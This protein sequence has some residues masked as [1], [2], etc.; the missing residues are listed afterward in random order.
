MSILVKSEDED[1]KCRVET[2]SPDRTQS[3]KRRR[4]AEEEAT[5]ALGEDKKKLKLLKNPKIKD[6]NAFR[7]GLDEDTLAARLKP[8]GLDVY[9]VP[10]D[11]ADASVPGSREFF[12]HHFGG[13]PQG[14]CRSSGKKFLQDHPE[15]R[16]RDFISLKLTWNPHAPPLSMLIFLGS[17]QWLYL[18]EYKMGK[19]APLT[20]REWKAQSRLM[21]STWTAQTVT[22]EEWYHRQDRI[23][24]HLRKQL[25]RKPT[26][27]DCR[28]AAADKDNQFMTVTAKDVEHEY[29]IG[30]FQVNIWTMKCVGY[31]EEIQ[32]PVL[33][34][35]DA[36][37][38]ELKAKRAETKRR[39]GESKVKKEGRSRPKKEEQ[40]EDLALLKESPRKKPGASG[41]KRKRTDEDSDTES[42]GDGDGES[43]RVV[44]GYTARPSTR[45]PR[46]NAVRKRP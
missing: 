16:R 17:G 7:L 3:R 45:N 36:F 27:E 29:D 8:I 40:V 37:D 2:V 5:E 28:A 35:F 46:P 13:A 32:Q 42:D 22:G 12:S 33:D 1:L 26:D 21:K 11:Q 20:T 14:T 25:G 6:A 18:G 39:A 41:K 30:D 38:A 23:R 34:K 19:T 9:T 10:M 44:G 24:I 15:A 43:I 4:V 31:D